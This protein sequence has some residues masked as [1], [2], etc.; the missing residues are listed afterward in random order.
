MYESAECESEIE[1]IENIA[2]FFNVDVDY[3]FGKSDITNRALYK[4]ADRS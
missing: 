1:I 3:L 4:V 2:D